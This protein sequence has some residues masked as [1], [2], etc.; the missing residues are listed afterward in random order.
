MVQGVSDQETAEFAGEEM[1][2]S[3]QYAIVDRGVPNQERLHLTVGRDSNAANYVV[4]LSSFS[5][6]SRDSVL[7]GSRSSFWF[8]NRNLKAGD[9]V[10]LYTKGGTE[11]M[12]ARPDGKQN[13]FFF[14]GSNQTLFPDPSSCVIV[15]ELNNWITM[16]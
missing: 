8:P 6:P 5:T 11:S 4:L 9:N 2:L 14:W 12:Q 3:L 1:S 15:A 16:A 13:H 7:A 10:I